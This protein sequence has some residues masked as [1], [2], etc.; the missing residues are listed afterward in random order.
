MLQ[1]LTKK[2]Q[3][4]SGNSV[5]FSHIYFA[6]ALWLPFKMSWQKYDTVA[7][8][9]TSWK[10]SHNCTNLWYGTWKKVM[11]KWNLFVYFPSSPLSSSRNCGCSRTKGLFRSTYYGLTC[12]WKNIAQ[13]IQIMVE[14]NVV[15]IKNCSE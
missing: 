13:Q 1:N 3:A 6:G 4:F 2:I 8:C 9:L 5:S 15:W 7:M 14:L 10:K 12:D 11:H